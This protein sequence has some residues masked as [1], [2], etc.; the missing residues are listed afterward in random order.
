M[1]I[2]FCTPA[3]LTKELGAPKVVME[4]AEGM[5]ALGWDCELRGRFDLGGDSRR[6]SLSDE[7][8]IKRLHQFLKK[9]AGEFDVI[10]YDHNFL[11]Y[12]RMDFSPRT[13]FVARSVLLAHHFANI[14]IPASRNWKSRLRCLAS[15]TAERRARNKRIQRAHRTVWEADLVNV[16]NQHDKAELI[17]RGIPSNNIIT[18]P[19]GISD[20]RRPLFDAVSDAVPANPIVAFVGTFDYRKGAREFPDLVK[21]IIHSVPQARIRLLGTAGM[22]QTCTE[23][24]AH[25]PVTLRQRIEVVATF[26]PEELPLLLSTCSVGIFPSYI[27][28][29]G[30]GVLEMLA[31][32]LPVIAYDSP[33]P[34]M[35]LPPEYLVPRGD[36]GAMSSKV[37]ALLTDTGKLQAARTWARQQSQLFRW[38]Q[39]ARTTSDL[40]LK[41]FLRKQQPICQP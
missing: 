26:R 4:L 11:P 9:H 19:F 40:Y 5:R 27:E 7:A 31:A 38:E 15:G 10:D 29:F 21:N 35:M 6:A 22:F 16:C 37:S 28:G 8:Y 23:V 39:V 2:L 14:S 34:P 24:L 32:S 3:P 1:N 13:L 12:P 30:F 33:G 41:H 20:S 17:R 18:I 36:I 25:F